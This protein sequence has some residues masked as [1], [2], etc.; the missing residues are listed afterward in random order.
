LKN[1]SIQKCCN[2]TFLALILFV[3]GCVGNVREESAG[4][5]A[6]RVKRVATPDKRGFTW[7]AP[8][9][10]ISHYRTLFYGYDTLYYHLTGPEYPKAMTN[11][12]FRLVINA[13]YG[14]DLRHYDFANFADAS[15]RATIHQQHIT[16]RCQIFNSLISS[17]LYQDWFSLNLSRSD[18]ENARISGLQLVLT[19]G[20]QQYERIDLPA[21]YIQ[22]FLIA[23]ENDSVTTLQ[24]P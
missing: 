11:D 12:N 5:I 7:L 13:N 9:L 18:L 4:T 1:I 20:K 22:G 19:S 2:A 16:E 3:Y 10:L 21:N 14:G 6:G 23:I 17:C 15:T 24:N 8:E